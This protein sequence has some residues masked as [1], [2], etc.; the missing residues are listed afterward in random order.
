VVVT[1]LWFVRVVRCVV[2][3]VVG[4]LCAGLVPVVE[5]APAGAQVRVTGGVAGSR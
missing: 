2:V 5:Q 3:G 4:A 1:N